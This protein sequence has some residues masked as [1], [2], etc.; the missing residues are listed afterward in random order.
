M[1]KKNRF[2]FSCHLSQS[3]TCPHFRH[4][5]LEAQAWNLIPSHIWTYVLP[6]WLWA[7][8]PALRPHVFQLL[9]LCEF[10]GRKDV[11]ESVTPIALVIGAVVAWA[12]SYNVWPLASQLRFPSVP[13]LYKAKLEVFYNFLS[14]HLPP[15]KISSMP[16]VT[17]QVTIPCTVDLWVTL[18]LPF[19]DGPAIH[20]TFLR[21]GEKKH[22]IQECWGQGWNLQKYCNLCLRLSG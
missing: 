5:S 19:Q 11:E 22:Q 6:V 12:T 13:F 2:F 14:L 9:T 3:T 1:V 7:P 21:G 4:V 17:E 16:L 15:P 18:N 10:W 20:V 8:F